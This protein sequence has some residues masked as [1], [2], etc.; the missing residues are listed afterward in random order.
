MAE[1]FGRH[2]AH[3][4]AYCLMPNDV[5]LIVVPDSADGLRRATGATL[6]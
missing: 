1:W 6:G 5:Y 3:V 2:G 4:W